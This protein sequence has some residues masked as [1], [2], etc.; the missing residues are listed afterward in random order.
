MQLPSDQEKLR[1]LKQEPISSSPRINGDHALILE[2]IGQALA[3]SYRHWK[4]NGV[5]RWMLNGDLLTATAEVLGQLN[6]GY[7]LCA[8]D[9]VEIRCQADHHVKGCS[10]VRHVDRKAADYF[11]KAGSMFGR[12]HKAMI[13]EILRGLFG[14]GG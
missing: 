7:P 1:V 8:E 9:Q 10:V 4:D 6:P 5:D 11:V 3:W 12:C 2:E 14:F 13:G